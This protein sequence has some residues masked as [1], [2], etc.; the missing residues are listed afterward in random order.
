MNRKTYGILGVILLL[1]LWFPRFLFFLQDHVTLNKS[2]ALQ[3]TTSSHDLMETYPV[4]SE[5]YADFY[6][7]SS[8][9]EKGETYDLTDIS[10]YEKEMQEK[11]KERI[12]DMEQ[13]IT[14][15]ITANVF[16]PDILLQSESQ[17]EISF[18]TLSAFSSL[19]SSNRLTQTFSID[20][21]YVR[22]S[23]FNY[24]INSNKITSIHITNE[25]ISGISEKQQKEMAHA[26]ISYLGLADIEDWTATEYGYESYQAKLQIN[27]DVTTYGLGYANLDISVSPLGQYRH[28]TNDIIQAR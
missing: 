12:Q 22:S 24:L 13:A 26:M 18:G 8:P 3:D 5:I 7:G 2:Y 28:T 27:C 16:T 11:L 9:G 21:E 1:T 6:D 20:R 25:R 15:L 17:Y 19:S 10:T 4:I 14:D 23:D